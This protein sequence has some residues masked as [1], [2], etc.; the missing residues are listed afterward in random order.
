MLSGILTDI[1]GLNILFVLATSDVHNKFF[2]LDKNI[3]ASLL[4][5]F[6]YTNPTEAKKV[7]LEEV[8]K[9]AIGEFKVRYK[10]IE[11]VYHNFEFEDEIIEEVLNRLA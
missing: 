10:D 6:D 3:L 4:I 5:S 2:E 8:D 7:N 1:K 11:K 9:L